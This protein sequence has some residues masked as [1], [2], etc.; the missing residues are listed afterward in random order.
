MSF[1]S[2]EFILSPA[3]LR[4]MTFK[5]LSA[6]KFV[7]MCF[8]HVFFPQLIFLRVHVTH[9][10]HFHWYRNISPKKQPVCHRNNSFL[11]KFIF[12]LLIL[13]SF[14]WS[15]W[16]ML[17]LKGLENVEGRNLRYM[18]LKWW[19]IHYWVETCNLTDCEM[20][21]FEVILEFSPFTATDLNLRLLGRVQHE[22]SQLGIVIV[23][24]DFM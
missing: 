24:W 1:L 11:G 7:D 18:K 20:G 13:T 16:L 10:T 6:F 8:K 14:Q 5:S 3:G 17:Y 12:H 21:I 19:L 23:H 22:F 9:F 2:R 4:H 15:M